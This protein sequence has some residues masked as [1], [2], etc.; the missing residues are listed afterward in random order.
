MPPEAP[1]RAGHWA[2]LG[3]GPCLSGAWKQ[4][5]GRQRKKL[6]PAVEG[7]GT[8][9]REASPD[10][11]RIQEEVVFTY[12]SHQ[13]PRS[14]HGNRRF[15]GQLCSQQTV[16]AVGSATQRLLSQMVWENRKNEV[17]LCMKRELIDTTAH[18][19]MWTL[20]GS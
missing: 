11:G 20:L 5:G 10:V 7:R 13:A 9:R 8:P 14:N 12:V 18:C 2:L 3:T 1:L 17:N 16:G 19:N 15:R 4:S 6:G